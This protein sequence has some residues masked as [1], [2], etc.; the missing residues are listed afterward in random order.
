MRRGGSLLALTIVG[1]LA[2]CYSTR[3]VTTAPESG[4]EVLLDLTDVA[5]VQLADRIGSS[6]SRIEGIVESRN[7]TAYV[8][9]VSSVTYLTGQTNK[10]SGERFTVPTALVAQAR[11]RE[12][13]RSRTTMLGVGIAAALAA[14]FAKTNFLGLSG[15][16]KTP[17]PTPGGES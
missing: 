5:R 13:S 12:F 3:T 9:R 1:P 4:A 17:V 7:D 16:E 8:L 6:A 14:I 2:G 15:A 10:W 11:V